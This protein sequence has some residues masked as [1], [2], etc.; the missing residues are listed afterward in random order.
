MAD[1]PTSTVAFLLLGS[2]ATACADVVADSIV[3][4]LSRGE[5]QVRAQRQGKRVGSS[6][7][8]R[9]PCML[10]FGGGGK[11]RPCQAG[12]CWGLASIGALGL[13][14]R[15]LHSQSVFMLCAI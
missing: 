10:G 13:N 4:E 3:V 8:P 1:S 15:A 9:L 14:L 12:C 7:H 6:K 2:A 5:P 11:E